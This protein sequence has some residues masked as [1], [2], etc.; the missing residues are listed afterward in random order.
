MMKASEE[1]FCAFLNNSSVRTVIGGL[2]SRFT[3]PSL[4]GSAQSPRAPPMNEGC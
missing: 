4:T 1:S 2:S 3:R